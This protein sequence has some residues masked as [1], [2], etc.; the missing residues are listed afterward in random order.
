MNIALQETRFHLPNLLREL[1][2]MFQWKAGEKNLKLNI[3]LD[4]HL[5]HIIRCDRLGLRQILMN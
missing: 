3:D 4:P 2:E 5:P 1:L